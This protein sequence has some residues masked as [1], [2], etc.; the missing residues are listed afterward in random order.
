MDCMGSV[1]PI[2][3][4]CL[5]APRLSIIHSLEERCGHPVMVHVTTCRFSIRAPFAEQ[6]LRRELRGQKTSASS[7]ATMRE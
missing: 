3:A 2:Q 7:L 5:N 1:L 4:D 6:L